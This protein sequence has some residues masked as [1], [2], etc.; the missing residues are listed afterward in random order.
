MNAKRE[1]TGAV[2]ILANIS[3]K[4]ALAAVDTA[5]QKLEKHGFSWICEAETARA[6]G[7]EK[8]GVAAEKL[9]DH[10]AW[11]IV[12]GGDGTLLQAAR[13]IAACGLPL[14]GINPG[15]SLGFMTDAHLDTLDS[16]LEG[17]RQGTYSIVERRTLTSCCYRADGEHIDLG[18]A[19]N[20]ITFIQ[21]AD[22]RLITLHIFVNGELL[23]TCAADGV[24]FA[25]AT[26]STAHSMSAGGPILF[27]TTEAVVMTP[28]CP[29]TL[30]LRPIILPP[31]FTI[32]VRPGIPLRDI[33][34]AIDGQARHTM[35][36]TDRISLQL[37]AVRIA[38][39][40]S[41]QPSFVDVLREKLHWRGD[42][43]LSTER[44]ILMS[45]LEEEE[46][47]HE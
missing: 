22:A 11:L 43:R 29:H 46:L 4:N 30:S 27:P 33:R 9:S 2:G 20:D 25:T 16:A 47:W 28:I 15:H 37:G 13:T 21:G 3:K 18:I 32:E 45:N 41:Q 44:N 24:V 5:I 36:A 14:L 40:H 42:L 7:R 39:I 34:V 8:A 38:F 1:L 10:V 35:K 17:I 31:G 6:A 26:G 23:T 12:I 19:I